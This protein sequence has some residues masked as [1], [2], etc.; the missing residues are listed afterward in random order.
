VATGSD[1]HFCRPGGGVHPRAYGTF[2][3]KIREY[4]LK[5]RW[6]TV[7]HAVRSATGLPADILQLPDRGYLRPGCVADVVVFDLDALTDHATYL[8]SHRFS[9]GFKRV[10]LAG[11][12][13][14]VDDEYTGLLPGRPLR[15]LRQHGR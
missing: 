3:R 7:P 11:Q 5:R 9:T 14:V 6:V 2:P 12:A 15:P 13:A 1:G 10:Y 4:A 8:D